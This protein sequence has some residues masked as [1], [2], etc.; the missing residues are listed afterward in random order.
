LSTL[1]LDFI[2]DPAAA[3]PSE[4]VGSSQLFLPGFAAD[5]LPKSVILEIP[6]TS[7]PTFFLPVPSPDSRRELGDREVRLP[8]P[9]AGDAAPLLPPA[10][11]GWRYLDG[12]I[13]AGS[14]TTLRFSSLAAT[15][16]GTTHLD[17]AGDVAR[18]VPLTAGE[19]ARD[20]LLPTEGD[21]ARET[22]GLAAGDG[23]RCLDDGAG[24]ENRRLTGCCGA[25]SATAFFGPRTVRLRAAVSLASG[26]AAA[27]VV[28][29]EDEGMRGGAASAADAAGWMT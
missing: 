16:L 29:L 11:D 28:E 2:T 22:A 17:G 18:G 20:A 8:P 5:P 1:A 23:S 10:G 27:E 12:T 4:T 25:G 14:L 15:R 26:A 21:D 19:D 3:V 24:D 13:I 6:A 9:T 7:T